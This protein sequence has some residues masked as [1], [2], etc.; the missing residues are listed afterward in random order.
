MSA[1]RLL[2]MFA[3]AAGHSTLGI[4]RKVGEEFVGKAKDLAPEEFGLIKRAL[5]LSL[6]S[7]L[8]AQLQHEEDLQ[9]LAAASQDFAEGVV[10][11][12][13]KRP[14]HFTGR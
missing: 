6:V 1:V 4:P 5:N 13:E 14:A 2:S 11:F 9:A 8:S 7:D 3:A 12:H 10:A